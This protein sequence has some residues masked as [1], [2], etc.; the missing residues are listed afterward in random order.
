MLFRSS[1]LVSRLG[2]ASPSDA[3][4]HVCP[5]PCTIVLRLATAVTNCASPCPSPWPIVLRLVPIGPPHCC[6]LHT[7]SP[8]MMRLPLLI[9]ASFSCSRSSTF[10]LPFRS[11]SQAT[12]INIQIQLFAISPGT[13]DSTAPHAHFSHTLTAAGYAI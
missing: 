9:P 2:R 8:M 3:D 6:P 10:L 5:C 4:Y 12:S 13:M 1:A 11:S 7:A